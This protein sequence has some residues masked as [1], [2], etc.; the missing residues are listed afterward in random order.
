MSAVQAAGRTKQLDR[1]A[2]EATQLQLSHNATI[3]ALKS[4]SSRMASGGQA[5]LRQLSRHSRDSRGMAHGILE[6]APALDVLIA[7]LAVCATT[8]CTGFDRLTLK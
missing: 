5:W 8:Q 6:S 2:V 1:S 3:V 4:G 7:A